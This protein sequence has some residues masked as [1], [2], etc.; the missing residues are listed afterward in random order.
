MG[1]PS[2]ALDYNGPPIN[3]NKIL[4]LSEDDTFLFKMEGKGMDA[5]PSHIRD[6]DLLCVCTTLDPMPNMVVVAPIQGELQCLRLSIHG[7]VYTLMS[8]NPEFP[9]IQVENCIA[10][11]KIWGVVTH[12]VHS[13]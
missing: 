1:F 13:F 9:A 12:S 3:L 11:F 10:N 6:G 2:P 7:N 8:D 4:L 5:S